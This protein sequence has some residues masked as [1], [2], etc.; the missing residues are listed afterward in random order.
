M[1]EE[2]EQRTE[3]QVA[4]EQVAEAVDDLEVPSEQQDDVAG[5]FKQAWPKK[6]DGG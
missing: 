4:E 2:H 3:D 5:G 1:A 6:Y